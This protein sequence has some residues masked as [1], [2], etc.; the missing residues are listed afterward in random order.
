[1]TFFKAEI[2]ETY[3]SI[4]VLFFLTTNRQIFIC[5]KK[6]YAIT[7]FYATLYKKP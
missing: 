7:Q 6:I 4:S 3:S 2:E 1:M 5:L